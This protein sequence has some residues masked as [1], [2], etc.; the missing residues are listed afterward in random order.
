MSHPVDWSALEDSHRSGGISRR[1]VTIVSGKGA[2]IWDDQGKSYID[3]A[4]AQGWAIAGH[5]HPLITAAIQQQAAT[6]IA[7]T[8]SSY[9]DQRALWYEELAAVLHREV[10]ETDKGALNRIHACNSGAEAIEAAIKVARYFTQK[11]EIIAAKGGFHGRTMGALSATWNPKYRKPFAPLVPGVSHVTYNDLDALDQAITEQ[12][13][14]VLLESIQGEGGVHPGDKGYLRGVRELCNRRGVLL[15]ADEIQTGMGRT[16]KWFA[17][18]H[19]FLA[20]DEEGTPE[21]ESGFTPDMLV[22]GKGLGG[23]LPMGALAWREELGTLKPGTHGSTFGGNP[24][25]CAASRAF[26]EVLH[27]EQLPNRAA[28]LGEMVFDTIRGWELPVIR[29]V[30]GRGLMVGIELRKRVT[31]ILKTLMDRGVWALPAG[32]T[33][34]RLLPPLV[35]EEADLQQALQI[36]QEV[37][38]GQI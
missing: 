36:I 18:Q 6:L 34:L 8:E 1:P 9:N 19:T 26:F 23:G 16:G 11:T 17:C 5:S 25:C 20:E 24:I 12:T 27:E 7:H 37:L 28:R 14:A 2:R 31:P 33:V 35:I 30:R 21:G 15:I 29:E 10:G 4:S 32:N 3:C 38:D 22:M 13:A